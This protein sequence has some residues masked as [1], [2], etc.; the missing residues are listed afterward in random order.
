MFRKLICGL[1]FVI[2]LIALVFAGFAIGD[3]SSAM[4]VTIDFAA[5]QTA[6]SSGQF[7]TILSS[8]GIF[9]MAILN[10][11]GLPLLVFLVSLIGLTLPRKRA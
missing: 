10:V 11:F 8:L 4:G 6:I 3:L 2:S 1:F 9:L 7:M 5:V